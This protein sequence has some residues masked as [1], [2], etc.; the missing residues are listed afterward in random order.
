[1]RG[2][3]IQMFRKPLS[4]KQKEDRLIAAHTEIQL[5]WGRLT[6]DDDWEF[7]REWDDENVDRQLNECIGQL[8]FE[9]GL[10]LYVPR[11]FSKAS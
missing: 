4:R 5:R 6:R 10:S 9:K 7:V 8:Q 1:M 2:S 3:V 11:G